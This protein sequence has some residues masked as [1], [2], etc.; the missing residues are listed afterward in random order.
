M[1][2]LIVGASGATGRLLV[3][4]LLE[5]GKEVKAVVRTG[6]KLKALEEQFQNL[7][8]VEASVLDLN[9]EELKTLVSDCDAIASCLGHNMTIKGIFGKP[10]KLV[11]SATKRLCDAILA[12]NLHTQVKFVLMNTSGNR[13]RD[14]D[15]KISLGQKIVIA[16]LR[17]ILPPHPDNEQAAEHLRTEV[18]QDH[19]AIEWVAVRPDGLID[20][21]EVSEYVAFASPIRDAI[22]DAGKISRI[23]V[24]NFM[25]C[26][27]TDNELWQKWKGQMPVIYG[28]EFAN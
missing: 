22:F 26:L 20:S 15:E 12:N 9:D 24:A 27:V 19:N 7:T 21:T 3:K 17:L 11:T 5:K 6:S 28:K 13:N 8:I 4:Q 16:L 2:T 18:G 23:N 14:L 25:S 10:K 1:K